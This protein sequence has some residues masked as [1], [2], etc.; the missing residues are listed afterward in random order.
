MAFNILCQVALILSIVALSETFQPPLQKVFPEKK[1]KKQNYNSASCTIL[2][3]H[4]ETDFSSVEERPIT[5]NDISTDTLPPP[6]CP[7][8]NKDDDRWRN[9]RQNVPVWVQNSL[10]RDSGF[11][12]FASDTLLALGCPSIISTYR[13]ALPNFLALTD[14]PIWLRRHLYSVFNLNDILEN[15]S[16]ARENTFESIKYGQHSMQVVHL[17]RPLIS[18][19]D[20]NGQDRLVVFIHGG[21][22]GSGKPVFYRLVAR[23]LIQRNFSVAVI[24]Y[25]TYPDTD[26]RGQVEDVKLAT[27]KILKH[28]PKYTE[29]DVTIMGHS[30]GSHIGLLSILDE[31]FLRRVHIG[32]FISLAGVFDIVKHF[33]FEAGRGVEEMSPMKAACG[34][35]ETSFRLCSPTYLVHDFI[36]EHGSFLLPKML[37][38]HGAL[39]DV[40]PYTSTT[41]LTQELYKGIADQPSEKQRFDM[42]VLPEVGHADTVVQFMMGGETRDRVLSWLSADTQSGGTS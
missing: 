32:S 19:E 34:G 42:L 35:S 2:M 25:R 10:I 1:I 11:V 9:I 22:W 14:V 6:P 15:E 38:L 29:N 17:M 5:S 20:D 23:P 8:S 39:D 12:R 27:E 33:R 30:S 26:V 28:S 37:F 3:N 41:E 4:R 24:G 18:E 16:F 13:Q 36:R 31:D 21:A 40:V 7:E